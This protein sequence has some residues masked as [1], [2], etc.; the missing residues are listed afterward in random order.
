MRTSTLTNENPLRSLLFPVSNVIQRPVS[1]KKRGGYLFV[2]FKGDHPPRHVHV[3]R[4]K[5]LIARWDLTN[6]RVLSGAISA[7][8]RKYLKELYE[9]VSPEKDDNTD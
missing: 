8:V 9:E 6:Q 5:K 3:F 4:G 1:R 2:S 7:Q